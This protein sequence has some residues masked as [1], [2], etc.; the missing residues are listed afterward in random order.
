MIFIINERGMIRVF[1]MMNRLM[2]MNSLIGDTNILIS[3]YTA[4]IVMMDWI[5]SKEW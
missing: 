2:A 4:L 1:I 3:V 5:V